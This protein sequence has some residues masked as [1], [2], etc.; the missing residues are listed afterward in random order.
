MT[1]MAQAYSRSGRSELAK[2][3]LALAVDASGNAPDETI[4]YA[5]VL[6][7]E[8]RYLPAE[9]ILLSALR[10]APANAD[11][12]VTLGQ[13]YL[14]MEDF[15]R[16]QGVADALRRMDSPAARQAADRI[17]AERLNRERGTEE[18]IGFLEQAAQAADATLASQIALIRARL[19]T[20]DAAGAL[21]LA[22]TLKRE[23]PETEGIDVV[24]AAVETANGN[25]DRAE[26]LYRGLLEATPER[27]QIWLN[28]AGLYQR[29]G[30]R[31][32]AKDLVAEGLTH[33]PDA[34]RLLWA[35][36]SYMEQDGDIDGAIGIYEKLYA[37]DSNSVIVANNLAS[38][39]ASY[40]DDA[41]SLER[42]WTVARRL[43][44][45]EIPAMQDTYGWILQ[46]RGDSEEALPY[47]ESAARGVPNDPLVHYH[48]G[49][50][51]L[52]LERNDAALAAF[53]KAVDLAGP[54]DR[55]PQIET[56]RAEAARL[57][58]LPAPSDD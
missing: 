46:R 31:D 7:G 18:A 15:G 10:L 28:L 56:A 23:N 27:P 11:L 20:G 30:A 22:R 2:E 8:E 19:G 41:E 13:L 52:S 16:A 35:Q 26:E 37:Q 45:T 54:G 5:R 29:R 33:M 3:F 39:L 24:L 43:R 14:G 57:E 55:R 1:L 34:P 17:E 53:R 25:L 12:L 4:R 50:A 51:Y 36:A 38:L 32:Q 40:R 48:L 49:Q 58:A 6:I 21:E 9:D 47:L 42:A 44:D